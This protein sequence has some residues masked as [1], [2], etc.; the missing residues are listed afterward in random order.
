MIRTHKQNTR[1][2]S[3]LARL[4]PVYEHSQIKTDGAFE[5]S[6]GRTSKSSELTVEEMNVFIKQLEAEVMRRNTNPTVPEEERMRKKIFAIMH[7]IEW[8]TQEGK[9]DYRALSSWLMKYRDAKRPHL[10]KYHGKELR[11]IVSS[12]ERMEI[13]KRRTRS[14]KK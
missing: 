1:L 3:V 4:A 10:S 12:F 5:I 6:N 8:V 9:L 2:H 11:E 7:A 14:I 13:G